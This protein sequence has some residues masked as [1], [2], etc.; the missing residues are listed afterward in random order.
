MLPKVF[1]VQDTE[2]HR[3]RLRQRLEALRKY[4]LTLQITGTRKKIINGTRSSL[5]VNFFFAF[6]TPSS[7]SEATVDSHGFYTIK[8]LLYKTPPPLPLRPVAVG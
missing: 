8:P 7:H 5:V 1:Q 6:S 4:K 2:L 3:M